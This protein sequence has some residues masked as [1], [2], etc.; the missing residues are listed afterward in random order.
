M[1]WFLSDTH[2]NHR[3]ILK[4]ERTEFS[5]IE[6]HDKNLVDMYEKL[7]DKI[8]PSDT[9]YHLGDF[10]STHM[11]YVNDILRDAGART[12]LVMGNHDNK[13]DIPLFEGAFDEVHQHPFFL[14]DRILL[15][16]VPYMLA[17]PSVLNVCG[18]IHG[19]TLNSVN[20]LVCSVD[21]I[22]Y[23][24]VSSKYIES[25]LGKLPRRNTKFLQETYAHLYKFSKKRNNTDVVTDEDGNIDLAAT[26]AYRKLSERLN[27]PSS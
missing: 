14:S 16:H 15:S 27:S 21:V 18:H 17:E 1:N 4:Y 8:K 23:K 13:Q 7:A 6:E 2:F 11:L 24:P 12:V 3:N 26:K 25:R 19:A 5:S 22:D 10:G 9:V 20:H